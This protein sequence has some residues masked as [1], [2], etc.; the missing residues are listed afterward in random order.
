MSKVVGSHDHFEAICG[1]EVPWDECHTRVVNKH[2]EFVASREEVGSC[3]SNT[4]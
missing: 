1:Q 3:R 4:R 2:V